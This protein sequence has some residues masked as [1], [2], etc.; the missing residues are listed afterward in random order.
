MAPPEKKIVMIRFHVAQWQHGEVA[1]FFKGLFSR[2]AVPQLQQQLEQQYQ[3]QVLLLNSARAGIR[4]AL[5]YATTQQPQRQLVLYPEYI[6]TSVPQ[7]IT[8]AGFTG[9]PVAVNSEFNICPQALTA[10]MAQQPLAVI[11]PHMYGVPAAVCEI[12]TI[13]REHQVLLIDDAAQVAG[14]DVE[15]Q[16]LGTF[17]DFGVI[18]FAQAKTIVT[19]VQGSGGV[20]LYPQGVNLNI[21]LQPTPGWSRLWPLWHFWA[22][23]QQDGFASRLDYYVQRF[24]SQLRKKLGLTSAAFY[25]DGYTI[26]APEAAVAVKQFATLPQRIS[27]LQQQAT[28]VSKALADLEQLQFPQLQAG[29]YL[30]RLIVRSPKL[31]PAELTKACLKLGIKT[32]TTYGNSSKSFDGSITSGLLELPWQGLQAEEVTSLLTKLKTLNEQ[33]KSLSS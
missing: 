14:V 9:L 19:G 32:K 17:G 15:G 23:Y 30:T 7:A 5:R 20:L 10:L 28:L 12:E 25:A 27:T 6:C 29:R 18:S 3:R 13:C 11:L 21:K 22:S 4:I 33:L 24:M 31:A 26:S 1:A 8:E 2:A 16:L